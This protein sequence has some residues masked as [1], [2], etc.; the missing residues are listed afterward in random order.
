M[1]TLPPSQI[2]YR[3][4]NEAPHNVVDDFQMDKTSLLPT[5]SFLSVVLP[6][7]TVKYYITNENYALPLLME[8]AYLH[9][10]N[11]AS[12]SMNVNLLKEPNANLG[13]FS[14]NSSNVSALASRTFESYNK[15]NSLKNN[16]KT[17]ID[18]QAGFEQIATDSADLFVRVASL[19]VKSALLLG[20]H[21]IK[22]FGDTIK[23]LNEAKA[24]YS[25]YFSKN[26][27]VKLSN[28][29][30]E[31]LFNQIVLSNER[32]ELEKGYKDLSTLATNTETELMTESGQEEQRRADVQRLRQEKVNHN[33]KVSNLRKKVQEYETK[34]V[35]D[36]DETFKERIGKIQQNKSNLN[37]KLQSNQTRYEQMYKEYEQLK[38][39]LENSKIKSNQ[40]AR[41]LANIEEEKVRIS[42][43]EKSELELAKTELQALEQTWDTKKNQNIQRLEMEIENQQKMKASLKNILPLLQQLK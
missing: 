43:I 26:D 38:K 29:S 27:M 34:S 17:L 25:A 1:N 9:G 40:Y 15:L 20:A 6:R 7:D 12:V 30:D 16:L 39:Q 31:K 19:L 11:S 21:H 28:Q 42:E 36:A 10:R 14:R 35:R 23:Q 3:S 8:A 24:S 33:A 5:E 41:E 18:S 32:E 13:K 4:N 2:Y 37:A 22:D